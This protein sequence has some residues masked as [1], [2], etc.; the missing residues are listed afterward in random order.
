MV[1]RVVCSA[2]HGCAANVA[3]ILIPSNF[4]SDRNLGWSAEKALLLEKSLKDLK[5]GEKA[6]DLQGLQSPLSPDTNFT[7]AGPAFL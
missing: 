6:S 2:L 1:F 3:F 7:V 4:C 5:I